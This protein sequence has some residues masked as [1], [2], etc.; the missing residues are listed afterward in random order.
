MLVRRGIVKRLVPKGRGATSVL[1]NIAVSDLDDF[2]V[3]FRATGKSRDH[4]SKGMVDN[5]MASGIA[6][7]PA[8]DIV[9]LVLDGALSRVELLSEDLE[10]RSVLVDPSEVLQKLPRDEAQ[11]ALSIAEVARTLRLPRFVLED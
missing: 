5:I 7:R 9:L 1:N 6:R 2:L 3:R 8:I 10:F 11:S 4:P